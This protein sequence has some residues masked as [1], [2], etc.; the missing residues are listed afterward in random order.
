MVVLEGRHG[1]HAVERC[2]GVALVEPGVLVELPRQYRL[3]IVAGQL[4]VGPIDDADGPLQP[5]P[6]QPVAHGTV[7]MQWQ[8]ERRAAGLVAEALVA[9][10]PRGHDVLDL[11]RP[12]PVRGGRNRAVVGAEADDVC[13]LAE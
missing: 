12:V 8:H 13:L 1:R 5:R 10:G 6:G 3:E 9:S 11:H 2:D 7:A 4:G